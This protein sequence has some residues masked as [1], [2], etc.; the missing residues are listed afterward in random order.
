MGEAL[1]L[2]ERGWRGARECS[3]L[4]NARHV[5]VT[6]LIKGSLTGEVRHM[7]APY[8]FIS[9]HDVP[10][11]LFPI[12]AWAVLLTQTLRG[13]LRWVLLDNERTLGRISA[14]CRW[15]RVTLVWVR[16]YEN[17]YELWVDGRAQAF[18]DTFAL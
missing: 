11:K 3:L 8:P 16:E 5:R 12:W 2:V 18:H 13:R 6:H 10:R 17:H 4:L 7:I 1:S 15:C 14:W 9:I